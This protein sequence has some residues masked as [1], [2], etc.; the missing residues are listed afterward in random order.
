MP[1]KPWI[2]DLAT[3]GSL[4][5]QADKNLPTLNSGDKNNELERDVMA[6]ISL[7]CFQLACTNVQEELLHITSVPIG[8]GGIAWY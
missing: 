3:L 7:H 6:D 2:F 8:I 5:N 1:S 4:S